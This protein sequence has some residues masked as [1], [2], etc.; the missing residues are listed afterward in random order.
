MPNNKRKM[1]LNC[2]IV[3]VGQHPAGWRT[4]ND[5]RAF[6]NPLFYQEIAKLA[7]LGKFDA[8]F[9]SDSLSPYCKKE[10]SFG[11]TIQSRPLESASV[12]PIARVNAKSV[13]K[14]D[15]R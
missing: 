6:I 15:Q 8:L 3:G 10:T 14:T 11:L 13:I 12:W 2:H 9:F 4:Q 7:E 5:T 1:H